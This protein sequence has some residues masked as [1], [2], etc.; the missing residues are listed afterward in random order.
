MGLPYQTRKFAVHFARYTEHTLSL[1]ALLS[2]DEP[3][4]EVVAGTAALASIVKSQE[5]DALWI[6]DR[7]ERVDE[8]K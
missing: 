4:A 6:S 5:E 7:Q 8:G 3:D 2:P 1:N